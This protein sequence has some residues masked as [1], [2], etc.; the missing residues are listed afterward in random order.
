MFLVLVLVYHV[1]LS[2]LIWV[3]YDLES[4]DIMT[5]IVVEL[6]VGVLAVVAPIGSIVDGSISSLA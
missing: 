1:A 3:V 2:S 6:P 4:A 5:S